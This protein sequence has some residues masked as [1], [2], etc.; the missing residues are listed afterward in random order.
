MVCDQAAGESCPAFPGTPKKLHRN[1]PDPA[2]VI[3]S[4]AETDAAFDH[5]FRM[6]TNRAE[7][8]LK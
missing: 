6:L 7:D 2:K 4:E 1:T 5:A 8:L 3:G